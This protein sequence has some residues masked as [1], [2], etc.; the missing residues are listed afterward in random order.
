MWALLNTPFPCGVAYQVEMQFSVS[1]GDP[2]AL[3]SHPI[4]AV[5]FPRQLY[6]ATQRLQLAQS[7][8]T[9]RVQQLR[10]EM[11]QLVP[12]VRV[13]ELQRLLEGERLGARRLQ[14]EAQVSGDQARGPAGG[15]GEGE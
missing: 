1:G 7:Q 15:D 12:A 4:T 6:G 9:Q 14:E 10:E 13:A 2:V 3:G 5:P 11:A 8:H